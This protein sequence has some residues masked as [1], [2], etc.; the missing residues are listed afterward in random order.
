VL[1]EELHGLHVDAV[2][3]GPLLAVDL[4]GDVEPVEELRD[5]EVLERLLFHHVAP[6]A[7]GVADGEEDRLVLRPRL[8]EGFV[9]PRAPVDR[10]VRMLEEVGA[11]FQRQAVE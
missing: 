10:I 8:R 4:D 1:G 11:R 3:V 2:H 9:S 6:V 5:L 7:G